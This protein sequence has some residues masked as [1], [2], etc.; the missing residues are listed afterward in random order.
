MTVHPV[1]HL[2]RSAAGAILGLIALIMVAAVLGGALAA[3]KANSTID[4]LAGD[5][6]AARTQIDA[7]RTDNARLAAQNSR[8]LTQNRQLVRFLRRHGLQ[9]PSAADATPPG[10]TGTAPTPKAPPAPGPGQ[11]SHHPPSSPTPGPTPT[12]TPGPTIPGLD[13]LT[14]L[15]CTLTPDLCPRG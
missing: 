9:V 8:I 14:E 12:P 10:S 3:L 13:I 5:L 15:I 4:T 1:H 6:S 7:L 11:P 2:R